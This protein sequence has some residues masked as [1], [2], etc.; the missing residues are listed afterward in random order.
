MCCATNERHKVFIPPQRQRQRPVLL[1]LL[2]IDLISQ[3]PAQITFEGPC[4]LIDALIGYLLTLETK[5][6]AVCLLL[7]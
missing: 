3:R 6:V 1:L 4:G 2:V 7:T 5:L